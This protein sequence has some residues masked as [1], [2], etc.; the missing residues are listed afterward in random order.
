MTSLSRPPCPCNAYT[1]GM[2]ADLKS[3]CFLCEVRDLLG[4]GKAALYRLEATTL[5]FSR[6]SGPPAKA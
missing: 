1:T 3:G 2:L 5:A 4:V 6:N